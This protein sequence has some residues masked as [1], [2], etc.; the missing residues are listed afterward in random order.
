VASVFLYETVQHRTSSVQAVPRPPIAVT[1]NIEY[2]IIPVG[3]SVD[4]L[5]SVLESK[6][7]EGS[8]LAAPVVNNGTTTSLIF[9][10]QK[11]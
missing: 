7:N 6:G 8:E 11:K 1:N 9:K 2:S 3:P 10:R 5:R 4:D